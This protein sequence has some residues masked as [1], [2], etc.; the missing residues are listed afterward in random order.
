MAQLIWSPRAARDFHNICEYIARDSRR[1]AR[2][3]GRRLLQVIESIPHQP[4]LGAIVPEYERHD[5]RERMLADYRIVYRLRDDGIEIVAI[6]HGAR[7][8]P[9][10]PQE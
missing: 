1:A 7:L 6:T 4:L 5:I 10:S 9:R 8:L 3:F 2:K